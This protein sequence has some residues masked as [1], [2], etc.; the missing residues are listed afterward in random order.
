MFIILPVLAFFLCL[1]AVL[2][3]SQ[4]SYCCPFFSCIP[5]VGYS[6]CFWS[7]LSSHSYS[8]SSLAWNTLSVTSAS[9][10][11]SSF[12]GIRLH[13]FPWVLAHNTYSGMS[14]IALVYV[15]LSY[16][17][18]VTKWI[19]CLFSQLFSL[20]VSCRSLW[21]FQLFCPCLWEYLLRIFCLW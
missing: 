14:F 6:I 7:V 5:L 8:T 9:F 18:S 1:C 12:P 20:R 10:P 11:V 19:Y 21:L 2:F 15:V 16:G 17:S 4:L 3:V 13:W